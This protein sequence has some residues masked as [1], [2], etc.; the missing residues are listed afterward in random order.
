M[1]IEPSLQAL[2]DIE[3]IKQLKHRYIRCM[4]EERYDDLRE[5]MTTDVQVAY[6]DGQYVFDDLDT[7]IP[8]LKTS[9]VNSAGNIVYWLAGMPEITLESADRATG[10]WAFTHFH[11]NTEHGQANELFAYY[12]DEYR[13]ENGIW[14]ISNTG[15]KTVIDRVVSRADSPF[16]INKPSWAVSSNRQ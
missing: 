9:M 2:W 4:A 15:Y 3:Q 14:R 6:S 5:I 7:L 1:N 11:F 16:T 10:I 8:F 12:R 13:K